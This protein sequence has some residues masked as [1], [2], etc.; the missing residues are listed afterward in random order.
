MNNLE[1]RDDRVEDA[2]AESL[3]E[4]LRD[5]IKQ[6]PSQVTLGELVDATRSNP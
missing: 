1:E 3:R 5:V 2:W 4:V 6:L